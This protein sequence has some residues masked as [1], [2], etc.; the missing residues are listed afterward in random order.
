MISEALRGLVGWYEFIGG[1]M[2]PAEMPKNG[3][4]GSFS[5]AQG[6]GT[7]YYYSYLFPGDA[8]ISF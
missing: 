4:R 6:K 1:T 8:H 5:L 3:K 2:I 7:L